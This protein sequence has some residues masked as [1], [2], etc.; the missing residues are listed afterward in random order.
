MRTCAETIDRRRRLRVLGAIIFWIIVGLIAGAL[1]KLVMPGDDPGGIIVTIIIGIVG[2][3]VG[4]WLLSFLGLGGA[5][6]GQWIGS[7][8]AGFIGA[9]IL[10]AIYRLVAG[11]RAV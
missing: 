3:V 10:L 2:A 8:I 4:G 5:G 9:V 6:T 7:I 1:A 11:R